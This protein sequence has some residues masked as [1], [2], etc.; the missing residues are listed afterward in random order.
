MKNYPEVVQRIH[1]EFNTAGETL[2]KQAQQIL[3]GNVVDELKV[4]RL[5][6]VGFNRANDV[7]K[8]NKIKLTKE[9]ADF[10]QYYEHNYPLNKFITE[11]QVIAINKKYNLVCAPI[12]MYKGFVPDFNLRQIESFFVKKESDYKK[13]V[14][15][16]TQAWN[17][18]VP[19]GDFL[20][21][22]RGA[23]YIHKKLGMKYI[24]IDHPALNW[25][26]S[27]ELFSAMGGYVE[28][29]EISN[30]EKGLFICAPKKDMDLKGLQKLGAIF[31]SFTTV[32]VP[33]PVVLQ[34]VRGGYLIVAAWGDEASDEIVV[35]QKM[36]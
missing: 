4:K 18:G 30:N 29:F 33:D 8:W 15:K 17:T 1:H 25:K 6:A 16:I 24:P 9:I 14:V 36:N 5:Q 19:G 12:E 7:Q 32:N 2:L 28:Q 31:T 27:D 35:N 3:N 11:E 10:V 20:L 22:R 26:R 34:P 23:N 13:A 21:R